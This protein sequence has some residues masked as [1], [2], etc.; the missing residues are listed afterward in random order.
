VLDQKDDGLMADFLL[1]RLIPVENERV[2]DRLAD[3]PEFFEA[4]AAFEDDLIQRWHRRQLSPDDRARFAEVYLT[5]PA[6]RARVESS[7]QLLEAADAWKAKLP[8]AHGAAATAES[9]YTRAQSHKEGRLWDGVT[10]WL[11]TPWVIPRL[12][13]VAAFASLAVAVF[14]GGYVVRDAPPRPGRDQPGQQ[15]A[16]RRFTMGFTLT[17]VGEKGAGATQTMDRIAIPA[18]ADD[19]RL[20]FD[21][22][23]AVVGEPYEAQIEALD[24]APVAQP[25]AP[26]IEQGPTAAV[27]TLMMP[28]AAWP[29]GDY[30]LRL[31]RRVGGNAEVIATRAFRI[32][33]T[34]TSG[35]R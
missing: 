6:R 20:T 11:A 25:G 31:H 8:T 13:G 5:V 3:E 30:V 35:G 27:A 17:A 33:R 4:M 18:D 9:V 16:G 22:P 12:T 19:I 29:N 2:A 1:R 26:R 34:A 21:V 14:V 7:R 32:T 24:G 23:G 15:T 10:R 28:A